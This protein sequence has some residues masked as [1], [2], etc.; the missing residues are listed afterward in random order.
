MNEQRLDKLES[1]MM[2]LHD[3]VKANTALTKDVKNSVAELVEAFNNIKGFWKVLEYLGK[4]AKP[5]AWIAGMALPI[6][7][8]WQ[9]IKKVLHL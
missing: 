6:T 5:M 7:F 9:E 8:W 3:E 2:T 4:L 1:D